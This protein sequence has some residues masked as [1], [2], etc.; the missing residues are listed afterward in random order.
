MRRT[1]LSNLGQWSINLCQLEQFISHGDAISCAE[2]SPDGNIIMTAGQDHKVRF[3]N[4]AT[5]Q[6]IGQPLQHNSPLVSLRILSDGSLLTASNEGV[7]KFW[8]LKTQAEIRESHSGPQ[9]THIRR[10]EFRRAKN[11]PSPQE[12]PFG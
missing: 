2:F 7:V 4:S 3:W 1:I 12:A 11:L 8:D 5:G 10:Y 6:P 9:R